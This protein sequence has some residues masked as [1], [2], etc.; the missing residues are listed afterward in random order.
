MKWQSKEET[1]SQ[2]ERNVVV[3]STYPQKMEVVIYMA[4]RHE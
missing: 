1:D 2:R 3:A 4:K